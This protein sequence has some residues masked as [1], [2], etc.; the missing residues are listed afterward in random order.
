M[1]YCY[2]CFLS[3]MKCIVNVIGMRGV[4][5]DSVE[6][7]PSNNFGVVGLFPDSGDMRSVVLLCMYV[8]FWYGEERK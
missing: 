6:L 1:V 8:R 4:H 2:W 3:W 5:P 7:I